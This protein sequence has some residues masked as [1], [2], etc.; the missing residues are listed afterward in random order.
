MIDLQKIAK[1]IKDKYSSISVAEDI[2]DP[3]D[4]VSTGNLA[5]DLISDGGIPFGY[6]TEFLGLT[7]SGKSLLLQKILANAQKQY[8]AVG[9]MGDRENCYTNKRGEQLGI[10]NSRLI[11]AKPQDLATPTDGFGFFIDAISQIRKTDKDTY[12]VMILDSLAA[13]DKDVALDKSDSGRKAKSTHEGFRAL[14]SHIDI[15][16]MFM[17]ANQVTYKITSF[18]DPRTTT[19]GEAPKY[20]STVRIALE[21][22]REITDPKRGNEVVG[23]WIGAEV[24]KTRLGPNHRSCYFRHLYETGIDWYSGYARLL[25]A[26]NYLKPKNASEFKAFK[27]VLL[28][29]GEEAVSEYNVEEFVKKHPELLFD[30]YPDYN[31][32]DGTIEEEENE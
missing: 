16:T 21:D 3:S 4:Y 32:K 10:D 18:G 2:P 5:L 25:A 7:S 27:Q 20:Y 24:I 23:N 8:D 12:V 11:V 6:C 30:K 28:T 17:V 14:L 29:Y 22:K 15:K 1:G 31:T 13:F 26:R 9:I 19:S